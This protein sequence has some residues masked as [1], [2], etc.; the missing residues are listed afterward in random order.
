MSENKERTII[1]SKGPGWFQ[2]L[3]MRA[4]LILRLLADK[5]VSPWLKVLPVGALIYVVWPLDLLPGPVPVDDAAVLWLGMYMFVE[6][7]PPDVVEEHMKALKPNLP[8]GWESVP[9]NPP[10]DKGDVIDADYREVK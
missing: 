9:A 4:K 6:L 3:A 1:P 2:D 7:C 5:R 8:G 10:Q